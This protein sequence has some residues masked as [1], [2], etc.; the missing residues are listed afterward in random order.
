MRRRVTIVGLGLGLLLAAW[1]WSSVPEIERESEVVAA[2]APKKP[3]RKV[4][5]F[6]PPAARSEALK[7]PAKPAPPVDAAEEPETPS[8]GQIVVDVVDEE[9]RPAERARVFV[10]GCDVRNKGRGEFHVFDDRTCAIWAGRRDGALWAQS[11][12]VERVV[13][14]GAQQYIQI[15]LPSVRTGG[16]GVSIKPEPGGVR[17]VAVMPG[18][19]AEAQGLQPGDLIVEVDGL[20]TREL[21]LHEFIRTMTGPEGSEVDFSVQYPGEDGPILETLTIERQFLEPQG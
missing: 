4:T 13:P 18:T 1:W 16:L 21:A 3:A 5:R 2:V 11:D 9:G 10:R 17:V 7:D 6:R 19:P 15:E 14:P 20:D 8:F 12:P